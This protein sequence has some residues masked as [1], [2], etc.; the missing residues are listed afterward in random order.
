MAALTRPVHL[1]VV[2]LLALHSIRLDLTM[3]DVALL[4]HISSQTQSNISI[5]QAHGYLNATD[6]ADI[7]TKLATASASGGRRANNRADNEI[8][9]LAQRLSVSQSMPTPTAP[10]A[11]TLQTY[12]S[13]PQS[14]NH[15]PYQ[16]PYQP[17]F[18]PT[19]LYP[20]SAPPPAPTYQAPPPPPD[21]TVRARALWAYN[22]DGRVKSIHHYPFHPYTH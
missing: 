21:N 18:P 9:S 4:A 17:P 14:P 16:P 7:Q 6:A 10:T 20:P 3:T 11:P 8:V 19:T 1:L 5:L 13:P 12:Q 22:E 15:Q 2:V